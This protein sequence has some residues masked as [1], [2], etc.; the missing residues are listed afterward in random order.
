MTVKN[1]G[2]RDGR[3]APVGGPSPGDKLGRAYGHSDTSPHLGENFEGGTLPS[4][5]LRDVMR[6]GLLR[7]FFNAPG[8]AEK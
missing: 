3:S 5:G 7:T 6:T 4:T 8:A 1:K 2:L